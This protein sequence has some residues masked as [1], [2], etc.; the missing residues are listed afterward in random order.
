MLKRFLQ[1]KTTVLW[2][3]ATLV[4][5]IVAGLLLA[6][7]AL[8]GVG[9]RGSNVRLPESLPGL[10][11]DGRYDEDLIVPGIWQRI[12]DRLTRS[13]VTLSGE[14]FALPHD[15]Y[16]VPRSRQASDATVAETIDA[17]ALL[18]YG[19]AIAEQGN[20]SDFLTFM[21]AFEAVFLTGTHPVRSVAVTDGV[22]SE[23]GE[24]DYALWFAYEKVLLIAWERWSTAEIERS[25]ERGI[26]ALKPLLTSAKLGKDLDVPDD[27]R[28]PWV[29]TDV[30]PTPVPPSNDG[31][32]IVLSEIDLYVLNSLAAFDTDFS[33][34]A[35]V[36]L[37]RIRESVSTVGAPFPAYAVWASD[38]GVIQA[39]NDAFTVDTET[40]LLTLLHLAEVGELS[41]ASLDFFRQQ[42]LDGNGLSTSYRISD[43]AAAG[44]FAHTDLYALLA[45]LGRAAGDDM[46]VETAIESLNLYYASS[47]TSLI[48]GSF[49]RD[50]VDST[51][52]MWLKDNALALLALH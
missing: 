21:N 18:F 16:T 43:G 50:G 20:R 24:E 46:L 38:Y 41:E 45:R 31:L 4:L 48:F 32:A 33:D 17:K 13:I 25:I 11:D 27:V 7:F 6:Y 22:V 5:L 37:T 10:V 23:A 14:S 8:P 2:I 12:S 40:V 47:Q 30:T 29:S 49:F 34:I 36:W 42:L 3:V 44:V 35:I 52:E 39:S 19:Q 1:N 51:F 28:Y 9:Q 26:A 15:V